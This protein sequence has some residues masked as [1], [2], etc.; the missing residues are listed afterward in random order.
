MEKPEYVVGKHYAD[1]MKTMWFTFFFC[2]IIPIGSLISLV[3]LIIYYWA[4]KYNIINK[5]I[6]KESISKEITYE[7]IEL[8]ELC[9]LFFCVINKQYNLI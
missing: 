6:V 3:G 1:I 4:D 8:L 2:S 9:I 7:M 5:R